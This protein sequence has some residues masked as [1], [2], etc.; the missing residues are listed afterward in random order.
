MQVIKKLVVITI[1]TIA[2]A[3]LV[4]WSA[5][6]FGFRSPVFA[7]L[8]NWLVMSWV[9]IMGQVLCFSF[10]SG[11]YR[12]R[13]FESDGRLYE[14]V[15]IRFFKRLVRRGP[16]SVLSP[17]LRFTGE[18]GSLS[19]LEVETRKA[20]TGHLVILLVMLLMVGYALVKSWLDAA[21][22]LLLFNV[23]FNGYPIMLQR[24]NRAKLAAH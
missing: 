21:G 3:F 18:P 12:I 6:A 22:W 11:Y 8:V 2:L 16:L 9:A 13:P 1:A 20:E 5:D 24:Y 14:R 4:D 7:F 19:E 10:R 15:G 23:L 17:T